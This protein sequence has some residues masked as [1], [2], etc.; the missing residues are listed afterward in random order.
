MVTRA[1]SEENLLAEAQQPVHLSRLPTPPR[2]L[3]TPQKRLATPP[4][5]LPTP[6]KPAAPSVAEPRPK[7]VADFRHKRYRKSSVDTPRY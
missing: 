1:K 3:P 5:R 4:N 6:P 7:S 2:R